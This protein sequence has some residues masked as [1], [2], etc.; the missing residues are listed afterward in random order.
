MKQ[1]LLTPGPTPVPEET[2]LDLAR[3]V[4]YHRSPEFK[5]ALRDVVEDLQHIYCTKNP[6]VTLACS[7]T[8]GM[9]AALT[10]ALAPG[11]KVICLITGRWG[12][13]WRNIAKAFGIEVISVTCPYGEA[14]APDQLAQALSQH[15]DAAGVCATLSETATGVLNDIEGY[16]KLVAK[17]SAVLLVDAISGL[18]AVPCRTDAWNVDLCVTGSQKALM[19]PP[20]LA[21]V[22]VSE[23]AAARIHANTQARTF[24]FDLRKYLDKIKEF[25][26]PFTPANTLVRA[27]RVS[28]RRLKN[29]GIENVWARH[30]KLAAACR[31]GV[32]GMGLELFA[33][34]PADAMTVFKPPEGTDSGMILSKMEKQYGLKLA[35][36]QDTLKGKILRLSHMGYVD[37]FDVLAALSGLELVLAEL[38]HAFEVGSGVAAFQRALAGCK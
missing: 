5:A 6:V 10:S 13:R 31:A 32:A 19:L 27:I 22:S 18:G 34:R 20:G 25:D 7:G 26:T 30:S 37:T 29:E 21:F 35:N 11:S 36:G 24:Y 9:E 17:T 12:E 16:G 2:L 28:L 1:R 38:G 14:I 3:P 23:K 8:G 33:K 15:P 4:F